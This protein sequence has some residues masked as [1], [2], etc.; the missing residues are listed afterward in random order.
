MRTLL[1]AMILAAVILV[2]FLP[3]AYA[4]CLTVADAIIA[5]VRNWDD[6]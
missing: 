3:V 4:L 6:D 2:P 1:D 5:A